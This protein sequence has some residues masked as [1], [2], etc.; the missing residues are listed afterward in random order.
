MS[1]KIVEGQLRI[2]K[3]I[4]EMTAHASTPFEQSINEIVNT[5][6]KSQAEVPD[7]VPTS[8]S[9]EHSVDSVTGKLFFKKG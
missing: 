7:I 1:I 9:V 6:L 2:L 3:M 5:T 8:F 4:S